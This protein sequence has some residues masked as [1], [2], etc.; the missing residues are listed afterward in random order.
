MML[1][2]DQNGTLVVLLKDSISGTLH[3][4]TSAQVLPS[5]LFLH[6][7]LALVWLPRPKDLAVCVDHSLDDV[8]VDLPRALVWLDIDQIVMDEST[9]H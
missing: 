8:P 6:S 1:S 5:F 9:G 2:E 7:F 4:D 3:T